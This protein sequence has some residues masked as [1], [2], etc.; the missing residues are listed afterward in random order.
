[1]SEWLGRLRQILGSGR[2]PPSPGEVFSSP[3]VPP[4]GRPP[5]SPP[6]LA[7]LGDAV[8]ELYVRI[9][10]LEVNPT[11]PGKLHALAIERVRAEAQARALQSLVPNLSKT[12]LDLVRRARN[13]KSRT[14]PRS[15]LAEYKQSTGLEALLGHLFLTGQ[16]ERLADVLRAAY[17]AVEEAPAPPPK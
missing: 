4:A 8:Y 9:R 11:D 17:A 12:E 2:I 7:Y 6:A 1:M 13:R 15:S 10:L 16:D 5:I 14:R 3:A